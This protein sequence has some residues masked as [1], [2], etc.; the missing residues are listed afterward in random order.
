MFYSKAPQEFEILD[1]MPKKKNQRERERGE[2]GIIIIIITTT[3]NIVSLE[4]K[5]IL[6]IETNCYL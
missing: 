5:M 3:C 1:A 4:I 2:C 6:S